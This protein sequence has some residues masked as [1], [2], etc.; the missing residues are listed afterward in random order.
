MNVTLLFSVD[1]SGVKWSGNFVIFE[2]IC[3]EAESERSIQTSVA[4]LHNILAKK[5]TS[6]GTSSRLK[7]NQSEILSC[8]KQWMDS[9]MQYDNKRWQFVLIK[10]VFVTDGLMRG[11]DLVEM[12]SKEDKRPR[13]KIRRIW[14]GDSRLQTFIDTV[15]CFSRNG[16]RQRKICQSGVC[17]RGVMVRWFVPDSFG[18][19]SWIQ[20]DRAVPLW[21][22]CETWFSW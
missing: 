6:T 1:D 5:M 18:S 16:K 11:L 8:Q 9:E 7:R 14:V 13:W 10:T 12:W 2:R 19:G 21:K 20:Y 4:F 17:A 3:F 22:K 15:F